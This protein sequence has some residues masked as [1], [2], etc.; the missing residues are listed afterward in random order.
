MSNK[1]ISQFPE[2]TSPL[3]SGDTIYDDGVTT[4]RMSIQTLKNV[5]GYLTGGTYNRTESTISLKTNNNEV[6]VVTGITLNNKHWYTD[7]QKI[8]LSDEVLNL[9]ENLVLENT[10]LTIN[11]SNLTI[12]NGNINFN[13]YGQIFINGSLLLIDSVIVNNGM[14]KID[15]SLIL[16]GNS[17]ITGTGIII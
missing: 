2:I 6:I 13:K 3:Y 5:I 12:D 15:G 1:F 8:V 9:P 14:I 4:Y 17:H 16:M 10:Q 11:S 7:E